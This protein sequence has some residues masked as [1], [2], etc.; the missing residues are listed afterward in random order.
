ME[1]KLTRGEDLGLRLG[2]MVNE[3]LSTSFAGE[4]RE[5]LKLETMYQILVQKG[6][7]PNDRIPQKLQITGTASYLSP[8]TGRMANMSLGNGGI[9]IETP[10]NV[11]TLQDLRNYIESRKNEQAQR[12]KLVKRKVRSPFDSIGNLQLGGRRR[13]TRRGG[14]DDIDRELKR[15]MAH[16][17]HIPG[18][19]PEPPIP[20]G[21]GDLS[22]TWD[23]FG[24]ALHLG[25]KS[26]GKAF[27]RKRTTKNGTSGKTPGRGGRRRRTRR[28]S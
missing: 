22:Q 24:R 13:R 18:A 26:I 10:I 5:T 25:L 3:L 17:P 6:I 8:R 20:G 11:T 27:T 16:T 2:A 15:M 14:H 4:R 1:I 19:I 9:I 28:R 23:R 12:D 21:V 7:A